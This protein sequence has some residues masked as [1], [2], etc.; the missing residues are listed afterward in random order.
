MPFCTARALDQ[1]VPTSGNCNAGFSS[2]MLHPWMWFAKPDHLNENP[3]RVVTQSPSCR[4][5]NS[6][7]GFWLTAMKVELGCWTSLPA[8]AT[9]RPVMI[10]PVNHFNIIIANWR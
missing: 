4:R 3:Y 1:V 9:A 2:V 8:V 5:I 7:K 10:S 6:A